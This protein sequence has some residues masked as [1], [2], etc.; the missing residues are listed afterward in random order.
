VIDED[1]ETLRDEFCAAYPEIFNIPGIK[2]EFVEGAL[3]S[4][5]IRKN[6][7]EWAEE[8]D[9]LLSIAICGPDDDRSL[10]RALTLPKEVR[11]QKI[12]IFV[13]QDV[14]I[15]FSA[16]VDLER[17]NIQ[18]FGDVA[19]CCDIE[20]VQDRMAQAC[21]ASYLSN[22]GG[23]SGEPVY[24]VWA[25]LSEQ[26]RRSNRNQ[27]DMIPLKLRAIGCDAIP[28]AEEHA[29]YKL[30]E[31]DI[32]VLARIEHN[33][34]AADKRLAGYERGPR[35]DELKTHPD[36]QLYDAL[37][38]DVKDKDRDPARLIPKLLNIHNPNL[39]LVK[40]KD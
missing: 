33:R 2:V 39:K 4:E 10:R 18:F 20:R 19:D 24:G 35:N 36:L 9:V 22:T 25:T 12:P 30:S 21:H 16:M 6:L 37:E 1:M 8:R 26:T 40:V 11:Q 27:A 23:K 29:E 3:E 31:E 15:G 5:E 28:F 38:E 13:R 17:S 34:W 7:E 14:K 32:E